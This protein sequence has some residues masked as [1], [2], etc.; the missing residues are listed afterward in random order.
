MARSHYR[1]SLKGER[2][3]G[4]VAAEPLLT[5]DVESKA[6]VPLWE[7]PSTTVREEGEE[8]EG[9]TPDGGR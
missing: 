6:D 4:G 3:A 2:E 5:T 7:I 1:R 9:E 8:D